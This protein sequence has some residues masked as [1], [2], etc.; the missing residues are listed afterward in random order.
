MKKLLIAMT[1]AAVG[2]CA[3]ADG[4]TYLNEAPETF[5]NWANGTDGYVTSVVAPW[6]YGTVAD[7]ADGDSVVTAADPAADELKVVDGVLSLNT[8]SKVLRGAFAESDVTIPA[9]GLYFSSKVTFKDPSDTLPTLGAKDKFALVVLDNVESIEN[10]VATTPSTNL[11]VIAKYGTNETRA[12]ELNIAIDEEWLGRSHNIEVKAYNNVMKNGTCAGFLVWVD[13]KVCKV[14]YSYAIEQN[15]IN[16]T[17]GAL[18]G[19]VFA[20]ENGDGIGYLGVTKAEIAASMEL[21]YTNQELL[22]SCYAGD[23]TLTS[24]DFQGQ[25]DVDDVALKTEATYATFGTD[26]LVFT[27]E[28]TVGGV[29]ITSD[30]TV[31]YAAADETKNI[32]F[33]LADGWVLK[34]VAKDL[35]PN[36]DGVYTYAYTTVADN[37][38]VVKIEA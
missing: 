13:N 37:N 38:Q 5:A 18:Q 36:G 10:E 15:V 8:G 12:Y 30:K 3:W 23:S 25:G 26:S 17:N 33:T 2:T 22:L 32:T 1:A 4:V 34:G 28:G 9:D 7:N 24:V 19:G 29:T 31:A 20:G 11:F 14:L 21:R 6:S 27:V 35:T 16:F